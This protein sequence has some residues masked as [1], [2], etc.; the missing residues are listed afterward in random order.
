MSKN[1]FLDLGT[2]L[3]QGLNKFNEK[4]NLFNNP[5]W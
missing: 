4:L 3:G 2:N 1:L 5:K